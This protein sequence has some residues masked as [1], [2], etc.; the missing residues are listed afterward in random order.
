MRQTVEELADMVGELSPTAINSKSFLFAD[1]SRLYLRVPLK[2]YT[3][4]PGQVITIEESADRKISIKHTCLEY[5]AQITFSSTLSAT[6]MIETINNKGFVPSASVDDLPN[7]DKFIFRTE[8][9]TPIYIAIVLS[10]FTGDFLIRLGL[11]NLRVPIIAT[12]IVLIIRF[13]PPAQSIVL[14]SGR[15]IG[16]ISPSL[17]GVILV[18]CLLC[19]GSILLSVGIP[20]I[21]ATLIT[22]SIAAIILRIIVIID[23][24]FIP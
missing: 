4:A 5:P 17:D 24:K 7:R 3:F 9:I 22:F 21:L 6:E 12:L 13:I 14:Q 2:R 15:Y 1:E 18:L 19:I 20:E 23:L 11:V 10:L 16:E 8:I